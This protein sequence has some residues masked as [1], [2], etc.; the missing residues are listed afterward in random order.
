M[1]TVLALLL[2][3]ALPFSAV[4]AERVVALAPNL[5]E[6]VCAVGACDKLVGVDQRS[7]YPLSVR[8]VAKIG[9]AFNINPEAVLALHPDLVMAWETGTDPQRM[10]RLEQLGLRVV[11]VRVNTLDQIGDALVKVGALI[12]ASSEPIA[13]SV[14]RTYKTRLQML[15]TRRPPEPRLGVLYQIDLQPI[16]T[17]NRQ[18]PISEA[19]EICGGHNVFADLPQLAGIVSVESVLARD[20]DVILF[21]NE[22]NREAVEKQWQRWPM[23]KA[24]RHKSLYGINDSLL[25]RA[26]PRMLDGI[27]NLCAV[28]DQVRSKR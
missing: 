6:L 24:V 1:K 20:P 12:G 16:Y 10:H 26:A 2:S 11:W 4:A 21:P 23:L 7:D 18:S 22:L 13:A 5:T 8:K 3:L 28:M 27:E 25:A 9:D 17:V 15:R 14:A 19:I